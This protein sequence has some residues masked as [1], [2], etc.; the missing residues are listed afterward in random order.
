MKEVSQADFK[1]EGAHQWS[2]NHRGY[3][4]VARNIDG[5]VEINIKAEIK[6]DP[7]AEHW[8][9]ILRTTNDFYRKLIIAKERE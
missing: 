1:Q 5:E 3:R 4:V 6:N 7:T 8:E 9:A 2:L